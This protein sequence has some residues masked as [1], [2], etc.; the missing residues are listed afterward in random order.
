MEMVY[1]V[2]INTLFSFAQISN[3][4][5]KRGEKEVRKEKQHVRKLLRNANCR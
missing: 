2:Y 3:Q 4:R 1:E 5:K